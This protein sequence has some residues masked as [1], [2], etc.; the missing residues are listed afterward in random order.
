MGTTRRAPRHEFPV[1]SRI[2]SA[3]ELK[4]VRVINIRSMMYLRFFLPV[5][6]DYGRVL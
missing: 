3:L 2:T 4:P 1:L 5:D 6:V